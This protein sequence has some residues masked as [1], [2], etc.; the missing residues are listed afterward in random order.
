MLP[1]EIT[2]EE[3]LAIIDSRQ[4]MGRFLCQECNNDGLTDGWTAIDNHDGN[5]W[6]EWFEDKDRALQWV[7]G[8]FELDD[9]EEAVVF[10]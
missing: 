5:A 3:A 1:I 8:E 2:S 6:V 9:T 10:M 7:C 4:P